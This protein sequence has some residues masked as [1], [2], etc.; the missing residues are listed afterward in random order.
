MSF[1]S[2]RSQ[3][4]APSVQWTDPAGEAAAAKKKEENEATVV[5]RWIGGATTITEGE[6]PFERKGSENGRPT[7]DNTS[8]QGRSQRRFQHILK[9][10]HGKLEQNKAATATL[11][12][13]REAA[14]E[15]E[16]KLAHCLFVRPRGLHG[17]EL[18][19][20]KDERQTCVKD[21]GKIEQG[22]FVL[23]LHP[24][25]VYIHVK[26]VGAGVEDE[27]VVLP[28]LWNEML[29]NIPEYLKLGEAVD[30]QPI[31]SDVGCFR[32]PSD[33]GAECKG[34]LVLNL[35]HSE[36]KAHQQIRKH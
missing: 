11:D 2:R 23:T 32:L 3:A 15:Q 1:L 22:N 20:K 30:P 7:H 31:E 26:F 10:S 28:V 4:A 33:A 12:R 25:D 14:V 19:C 35:V 18:I 13:I 17:D 21:I 8:V 27:D 24:P 6:I 34:R 36:H 9:A 29:S 5:V 16:R